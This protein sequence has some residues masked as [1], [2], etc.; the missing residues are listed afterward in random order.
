MA[1]NSLVLIE[2]GRNV[3]SNFAYAPF[4]ADGL[5]YLTIEQYVCIQKAKYFK[6]QALCATLFCTRSPRKCKEIT[7]DLDQI[8]CNDWVS[9]SDEIVYAGLKEKFTQNKAARDALFQTRGQVIVN[10]DKFD[11]VWGVGFDVNDPRLQDKKCWGQNKLGNM[12]MQLCKE[13]FT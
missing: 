3:L 4:V 9:V 7:Q 12:L 2:N 8:D 6:A 1:T 13:L 10:C 5:L 11:N